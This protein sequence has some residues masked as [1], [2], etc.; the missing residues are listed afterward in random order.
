M[1][2]HL[3]QEQGLIYNNTNYKILY[4]VNPKIIL[5]EETN[6]NVPLS[7]LIEGEIALTLTCTK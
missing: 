5:Y 6:H 4:I 3:L 7:S 1:L 2:K